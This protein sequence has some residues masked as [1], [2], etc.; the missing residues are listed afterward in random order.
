M[1]RL[2]L[3]LALLSAPAF[4]QQT[5]QAPGLPGGD[6]SVQ[7][8]APEVGAGRGGPN[9]Q[10][11]ETSEP[12]GAT[13][14]PRPAA[15]Q[16]T[17]PSAPSPAPP[18]AA[19]LPF[20]GRGGSTAA[21]QELEAALRGGTIGGRV[22]IPNQSAGL[23]IQ[24][25]GR[26][27]RQFRNRVL[28]T[29]GIFAVVGTLLVV[30]AYHLIRGP[31]RLRAGRSG[32]PVLRFG[33]LERAN[34]WMVATS[35]I[36]LALT[37]LNI[38]FGAWVLRPVIG[39]EAFTALTLAGQAVHHFISFAF[40]FGVVLMAVLWV[41]Q[42]IPNRRDIDYIKAGGPLGRRHV[43]TGRF[44]AGQKMLFWA[45]VLGGLAVAVSGYLLMAPGL[46]DNV[47]GQQWA[48]MAHGLLAMGMTAMIIGH[49]YI[50]SIGMEGAFEAMKDGTVDQNWARE[51]HDLWLEEKL[52]AARRTVAPEGTPPAAP[53]E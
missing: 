30:T 12:Q 44:N 14:G 23:L 31:I 41:G 39:P 13:G 21:E 36:L 47:I 37:G 10:V 52:A 40:L 28:V 16:A 19:P 22:S 4:A 50:G 38:T 42:N 20:T 6:P 7:S 25:D 2:L 51:H 43:A 34:H 32:R 1:R 17:A 29:A 26:D 45:V 53:A 48:H 5:Q 9:A 11:P 18:I 3:L 35:F 24:P 8:T 49:I 15:P 33:W 27:W 46:L